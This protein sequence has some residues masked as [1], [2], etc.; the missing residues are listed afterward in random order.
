MVGL[1]VVLLAIH[2]SG[3][4][5]KKQVVTGATE[6]SQAQR[7]LQYCRPSVCCGQPD[8]SVQATD[9]LHTS[10]ATRLATDIAA[11]RRGC[12]QP[13]LP[14]AVYPASAKYCV[15]CDARVRRK[16]R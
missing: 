6:P 8:L 1:H 2:M 4:K 11:T 12:V 14:F 13:I 15:I 3:N 16:V 10:S 5:Q 7:L 9:L